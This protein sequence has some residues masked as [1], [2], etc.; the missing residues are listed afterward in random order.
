MTRSQSRVASVYH[1]D[2]SVEAVLLG[3]FILIAGSCVN[4]GLQEVANAISLQRPVLGEEN[5]SS[6]NGQSRDISNNHDN[7]VTNE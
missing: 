3:I 7:G 1:V 2:L 5:D 6:R 4:D